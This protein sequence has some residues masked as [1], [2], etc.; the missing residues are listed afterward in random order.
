MI[1]LVSK[2]CLLM[3]LFLAGYAAAAEIHAATYGKS[4][5]DLVGTF[6]IQKNI[7]LG[8]STS[9]P[10]G[11]PCIQDPQDTSPQADMYMSKDIQPPNLLG[12]DLEPSVV[13]AA[14]SR[15]VNMTAH[16]IDDWSGLSSRGL[17]MARFKS[18]TGS[19]TAEAVFSQK[20]LVSGSKEDGFFKASVALPDL[21]EAGEWRMDGLV[22]ADDQGHQRTISGEDLVRRGL[23]SGFLVS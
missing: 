18:P 15:Q 19:Q 9:C 14:S 20:N 16:I 6:S 7:Q 4:V 2:L 11:G 3:V 21:P 17:T 8:S 10:A 5:D 23:P 1:Q 22:L 12:L 13:N